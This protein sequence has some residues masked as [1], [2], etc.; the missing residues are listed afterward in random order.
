MHSLANYKKIIDAFPR[1]KIGVVADLVA[2][3]YIYGRPFRL[4][5]EA[6]VIVVRYEGE[7]MVP[8]GGANTVN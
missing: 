8:G 7:E 3:I 6:P 5:R 4:S 1:L 2:D